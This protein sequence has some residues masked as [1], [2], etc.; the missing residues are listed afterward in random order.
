[1]N[2]QGYKEKLEY[3]GLLLYLVDNSHQLKLKEL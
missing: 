2:V 1:M 3:Q